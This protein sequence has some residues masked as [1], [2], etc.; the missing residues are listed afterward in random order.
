MSFDPQL[1]RL[2]QQL[3]QDDAQMQKIEAQFRA[4]AA[5]FL[6][7]WWW[8]T[9]AQAAKRSPTVTQAHGRDGVAAMKARVS[10]LRDRAEEVTERYLGGAD[11]WWHKP[12]PEERE[13]TFNYVFKSQRVGPRLL[14]RGLRAAAGAIAP[15][16]LEF[17]YIE[18]ER[19][20]QWV[21]DDEDVASPDETRYSYPYSLEWPP[22]LLKTAWSYAT[23]ARLG[24]NRLQDLRVVLSSQ[25]DSDPASLWGEP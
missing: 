17:G 8:E 7:K 1:R 6:R 24:A 18:P 20:A 4:E 10:D 14:D 12:P 23:R 19:L 11:V 13:C 3:A 22:A 21:D 2:E 16:L 5:R 9:A 15:I 25:G